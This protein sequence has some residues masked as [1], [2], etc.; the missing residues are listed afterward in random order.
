MYGPSGHTIFVNTLF[1]KTKLDDNSWS[2]I[3][4]V[5]AAGTAQNYWNVGDVKYITVNGQI[6]ADLTL[7]N[8][9]FGVFILG[10]DHNASLEGSGISFGT[11]KTTDGKEVCLT[12]DVNVNRDD[13]S[14]IFNMN[15]WG[16]TNNKGWIACDMRYDILGSTNIKPARYGQPKSASGTAGGNATATCATSPISNTL[17]A[18]LPS[19][20]RDVMK[21]ITKYTDNV[22]G[23]TGDVVS[24]V[25]ASIDYLPLLSEFEVQGAR[26]S[27]NLYEQDYQSQYQYYINGNSKIKYKHNNTSSAGYWWLRSPYRSLTKPFCCV[28]T[29]GSA[30]NSYTYTTRMI[31][32]VFLV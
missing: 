27:A 30:T 9:T 25:T 26:T 15:H 21:P 28:D 14:L 24:S 32:C 1:V 4:Q 18:A 22:A 2:T 13:G 16:N 6:G 29:D 10:F 11:F 5:S 3:S 23:G 7:S 12:G 17:M 31:A 20:L 19:D 8:Q